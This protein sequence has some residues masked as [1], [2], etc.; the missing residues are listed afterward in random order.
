MTNPLGTKLENIEVTI[1]IWEYKQMKNF[2]SKNERLRKENS[3]LQEEINNLKGI[4]SN[5]IK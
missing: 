5:V 4:I 2:H 1:P 3:K